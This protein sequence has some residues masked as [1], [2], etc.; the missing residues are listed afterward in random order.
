M[1]H[2]S[3]LRGLSPYICVKYLF[4][5]FS[6]LNTSVI[7]QY[8]HVNQLRILHESFSKCKIIIVEFY[9]EKRKR[10]LRIVLTAVVLSYQK[11]FIIKLILQFLKASDVFL[12]NPFMKKDDN[13]TAGC[14]ASR[15]NCPSASKTPN[16]YHYLDVFIE[17]PEYP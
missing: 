13:D 1:L 8:I 3:E 11:L 15:G 6:L 16:L 12:N 4:E 9:W 14:S 17:V 10:I 2:C 5:W 7:K